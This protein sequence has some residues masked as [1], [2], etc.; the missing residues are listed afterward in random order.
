M[1]LLHTKALNCQLLGLAI[2]M[3]SPVI[4]AAPGPASSSIIPRASTPALVARP[5]STK[6]KPVMKKAATPIAAKAKPARRPRGIV[7]FCNAVLSAVIPSLAAKVEAAAPESAAPSEP[8][9]T[10][11]TA[12]AAHAFE[13]A[14]AEPAAPTM[15]NVDKLLT[16]T[17]DLRATF[18][19]APNDPEAKARFETKSQEYLSGIKSYLDSRGIKYFVANTSDV[20]PDGTRI[21]WPSLVLSTEGDH[22]LNR[23]A[24]G[25]K[26]RY[27][28][29]LAVDF[30]LLRR[31]GNVAAYLKSGALTLSED[32]IRTERATIDEIEEILHVRF[33]AERD[34]RNKTVGHVPVQMYFVSDSPIRSEGVEHDYMSEM[35]FEDV[36]SQAVKLSIKAAQV[37]GQPTAED[38]STIKDMAAYLSSMTQTAEIA[39]ERAKL[40]SL[41]GQPAVL[42]RRRDESAYLVFGYEKIFNFATFIPQ[43]ALENSG[44]YAIREMNDATRLTKFMREYF[45]EPEAAEPTPEELF[46]KALNFRSALYDFIAQ[47]GRSKPTAD[48]TYDVVASLEFYLDLFK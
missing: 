40:S 1:S 6:S 37:K 3:S 25:M 15:E 32:A 28:V 43:M 5:M 20:T 41:E 27:D 29:Q 47:I 7:G 44:D 13:A 19:S 12:D 36:W 10:T 8:T 33:A 4:F 11:I 34:E 9:P 48:A 2:L 23:F 46:A 30:L 26:R 16:E 31:Q 38:L 17:N 21:T 18:E 22:R 35:T 14:P 24:S 39:V 42:N 45:Y